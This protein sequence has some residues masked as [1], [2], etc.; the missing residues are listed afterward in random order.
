MRNINKGNEIYGK[1]KKKIKKKKK[2]IERESRE[3]GT[4][5]NG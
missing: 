4:T 5:G 3:E 2:K 1:E